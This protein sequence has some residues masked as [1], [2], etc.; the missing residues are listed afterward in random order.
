MNQTYFQIYSE[1]IKETQ[2]QRFAMIILVSVFKL[3]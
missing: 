2:N 1:M 3:Y